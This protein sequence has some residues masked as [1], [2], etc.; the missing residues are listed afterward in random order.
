MRPKSS[1][2]PSFSATGRHHVASRPEIE[3]TEPG[4]VD[5]YGD[6]PVVGCLREE[7]LE[8]V[9]ARLPLRQSKF[10]PISQRGLL[11]NMWPSFDQFP[12]GNPD[13]GWSQNGNSRLFAITGRSSASIKPPGAGLAAALGSIPPLAV[14]Q[15][16][17][18]DE[19]SDDEQHDPETRLGPVRESGRAIW[20]RRRGPVLSLSSITGDRSP[21][22]R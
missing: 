9:M 2:S 20:H 5:E 21:T 8:R 7:N 18:R 11:A 14:A 10:D 16:G 15:H 17:Q 1:T 6:D 13:E 4:L 19:A 12:A 3:S 22:L